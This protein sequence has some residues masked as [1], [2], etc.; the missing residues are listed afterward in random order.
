MKI[1]IIMRVTRLGASPM[2]GGTRKGFENFVIDPP[3]GRPVGGGGVHRN[4]IRYYDFYRS[5]T[6]YDSSLF[7]QCCFGDY[8]NRILN[9]LWPS[10]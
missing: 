1:I 9:I 2:N 10:I 8:S 7:F 5:R 3:R 6:D 4:G